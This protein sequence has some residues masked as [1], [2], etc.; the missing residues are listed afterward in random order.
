[1][2]IDATDEH[3][4]EVPIDNESAKLRDGFTTLSV[5]PG[6]QNHLVVVGVGLASQFNKATQQVPNQEYLPVLLEHTDGFQRVASLLTKN[7]PHHVGELAYVIGDAEMEPIRSLPVTSRAERDLVERRTQGLVGSIVAAVHTGLAL[8]CDPNVS[9]Y[10]W[11]ELGKGPGKLSEKLRDTLTDVLW[12]ATRVKVL[13]QFQRDSD[14]KIDQE[15][16]VI[17]K[18][19]HA[20]APQYRPVGVNGKPEGWSRSARV[21]MCQAIL[22]GALRHIAKRRLQTAQHDH[23]KVELTAVIADDGEPLSTAH[24]VERTH[25]YILRKVPTGTFLN[26]KHE[27]MSLDLNAQSAIRNAMNN[28]PTDPAIIGYA[29]KMSAPAK[30]IRASLDPDKGKSSYSVADFGRLPLAPLHA[31]TAGLASS[32]MGMKDYSRFNLSALTSKVAAA[33]KCHDKKLQSKNERHHE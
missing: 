28:R 27:M 20:N 2:A 12:R 6:V 21:M 7:D 16:E 29:G 11:D 26:Y 18:F 33:A 32:A 5:K 10:L 8:K 24:K 17:R 30:A 14:E 19:W 22:T 9:I 23:V 1:M 4:H 3:E 15:T 25:A 31:A 13:T